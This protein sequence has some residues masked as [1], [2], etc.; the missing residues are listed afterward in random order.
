MRALLVGLVVVGGCDARLGAPPAV[1]GGERGAACKHVDVVFAVDNSGSTHLEKE[2]LRNDAF[3]G[4]AKGLRDIA[5]GLDD[6]RVGL[7][8]GCSQSASLHTRGMSG[9]CN[10]AGGNVWM[11]SS[12]AHLDDEFRC[13]GDIDSRDMLCSGN[14]DDEQPVT[15]ATT[16]LE[17]EWSGPG[18]PNAGF[19]RDDALLVV[20]ALTDEDEQPVPQAGAQDVYNRLVA[21]K[22]DVDRL[23][24]V[25]I[26]G[27]RDCQGDYGPAREAR[28][29]KDVTKLF[30]DHQRGVFWDLCRGDLDRGLGEALDTIESACEELGGAL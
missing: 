3:P 23:A 28:E 12:A 22:G 4:F 6:F 2:D 20:V 21:V 15:T 26:G 14:D 9:P 8:D 27:A 30:A 19:L 11:E 1:G 7:V 18:K 5:G 24:F 10:F 17:P 16:A 25:G 13:V 29:L